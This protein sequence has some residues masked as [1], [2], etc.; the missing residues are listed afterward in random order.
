MRQ[1][2]FFVDTRSM[3]CCCFC[4]RG[5][6]GIQNQSVRIQKRRSQFQEVKIIETKHRLNKEGYECRNEEGYE[7]RSDGKTIF[8]WAAEWMR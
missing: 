7:C 6:V 4:V 1:V 3:F 5:I 8:G 2:F